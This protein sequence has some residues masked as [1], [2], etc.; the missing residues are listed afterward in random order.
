MVRAHRLGDVESRDVERVKVRAFSPLV[1]IPRCTLGALRACHEVLTARNDV[2]NEG[3]ADLEE[4][5][6]MDH[7]VDH[8]RSVKDGVVSPC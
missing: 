3:Q 4:K 2:T 7:L 5:T 6:R 8:N 1:L